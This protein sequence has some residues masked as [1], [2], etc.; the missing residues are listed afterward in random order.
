MDL[1][2]L[3]TLPR[4]LLE[5]A[6]S[7]LSTFDLINYSNCSPKATQD[8]KNFNKKPKIRFE[9]YSDERPSINV[10][11]HEN[12]HKDEQGDCLF[13]SGPVDGR[14][15]TEVIMFGGRKINAHFDKEYIGASGKNPISGFFIFAKHLNEIFNSPPVYRLEISKQD[16]KET[17]RIID[18]INQRGASEVE[19]CNITR[20]AVQMTNTDLSYILDHVNI[21]A[22]LNIRCE[23]QED[24]QNDL[25]KT[26][27]HFSC[28]Y[29][30]WI[31]LDQ[32][33]SPHFEFIQVHKT[34]FTNQDM[35]AYVEK[36]L[37]GELPNL[38]YFEAQIQGIDIDE[39]ANG[40]RTV[41]KSEYDFEC[42]V[43]YKKYLTQFIVINGFY[44]F[45]RDDGMIVTIGTGWIFAEEPAFQ[46]FVRSE[47]DLYPH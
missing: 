44:N 43:D 45:K 37:A 35:S 32:L 25:P 1:F 27:K 36:V 41:E 28:A 20:E 42:P 29:S 8:V 12:P 21:R 30:K 18:W 34:G 7:K 5:M 47:Y 2:N 26:L 31:T 9:I 11:H 10:I 39:I 22:A 3:S 13:I 19:L 23:V 38:I 46:I 17:K 16:S 24:F 40:V 15:R 4:N 6:L 14:F 33:I